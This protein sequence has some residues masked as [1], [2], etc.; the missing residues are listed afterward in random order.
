MMVYLFWIAL[1]VGLLLAIG[2]VSAIA[3]MLGLA[4]WTALAAAWRRLVRGRR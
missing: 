3:G 2:L 1:G 4:L